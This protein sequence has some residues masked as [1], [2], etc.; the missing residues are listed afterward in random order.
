MTI[1]M[2]TLTSNFYLT[3]IW[4]SIALLF[5]WC[6]IYTALLNTTE[7]AAVICGNPVPMADLYSKLRAWCTCM[8]EIDSISW[9]PNHIFSATYVSSATM[10]FSVDQPLLS[11]FHHAQISRIV[12]V[13]FSHCMQACLLDRMWI[14]GT[15]NAR[16]L[17]LPVTALTIT[18]LQRVHT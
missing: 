15:A 1:A 2:E 11:L 12:R 14:M 6:S 16:V 8:Q 18:S 10:L 5:S 13:T 3:C 9:H 7:A 4:C 17:P